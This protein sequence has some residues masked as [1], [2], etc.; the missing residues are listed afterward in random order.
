VITGIPVRLCRVHGDGQCSAKTVQPLTKVTIM[1]NLISNFARVITSRGSTTP[2]SS[3]RIESA[4]APPPVCG[5]EIYRSRAFYLVFF[6]T[7]AYTAQ[8]RDRGEVTI[9]HTL[10]DTFVHSVK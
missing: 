4:G 10:E 2:P 8:T 3:I 5:G 1:N 6:S 7:H 9:E